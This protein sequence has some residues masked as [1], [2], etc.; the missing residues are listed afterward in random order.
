VQLANDYYPTATL[1]LSA[2]DRA[3]V[4]GIVEDG[5]KKGLADARVSVVGYPTEAITTKEGGNFVLPAHAAD[6]Q[7]VELH[8]ER[9]GEAVDQWHPA[10]R[11]P[12]HLIF[13]GKR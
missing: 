10:G 6:G 9:H 7:Q 5:D 4:I 12:A 8:A 3:H 13:D 1:L 11:F 2:D